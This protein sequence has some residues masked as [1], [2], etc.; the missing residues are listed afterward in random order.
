MFYYTADITM[1][2][3][4]SFGDAILGNA[5][6]VFIRGDLRRFELNIGCSF[7]YIIARVV[8]DE[9]LQYSVIYFD[10]QENRNDEALGR[11]LA[12]LEGLEIVPVN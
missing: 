2:K 12:V 4:N 3:T 6:P 1:K 8:T 10:V 7:M 5:C 11:C 9:P